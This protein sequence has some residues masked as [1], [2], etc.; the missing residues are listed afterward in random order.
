MND[1]VSTRK[2]PWPSERGKHPGGR[3]KGRK[4]RKTLAID[5][6]NKRM[7]ELIVRKTQN[8]IRAALIPAMGQTFVYKIEEEVTGHGPKG[9]EYVK[10]KHTLVTDPEEIARA[11]DQI[12][13]GGRDPDDEY[14]YVTAKEPDHKAIDMLLNRGY[15]KP[16]ETIS[17]NGEVKFTLRGLADMRQRIASPQEQKAI[18]DVVRPEETIVDAEVIRPNLSEK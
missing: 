10:R 5:E 18:L 15:G 17:L 9:G 13:E 2:H 14:Y 12:E 3:P 8:L 16:K 6:A 4:N 7:N 11:L 1:S